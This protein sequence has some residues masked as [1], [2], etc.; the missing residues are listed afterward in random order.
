MRYM[1]ILCVTWVWA[2]GC[3]PAASESGADSESD[4]GS[5]GL[6]WDLGPPE[7][8]N[9]FVFRNQTNTDAAAVRISWGRRVVELGPVAARAE[10][11]GVLPAGAPGYFRVTY[12]WADGTVGGTDWGAPDAGPMFGRWHTFDRYEDGA[13]GASGN[14]PRRH[15]SWIAEPGAAADPRRQDGSG[16]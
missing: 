3:Q 2:A 14:R 1:V 7:A 13:W 15:R 4:G 5:D 9:E 11:V 10:V 12:V 6:A 16:G 8:Q